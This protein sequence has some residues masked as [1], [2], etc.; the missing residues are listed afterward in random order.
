MPR[1]AIPENNGTFDIQRKQSGSKRLDEL[2]M[3]PGAPESWPHL[4]VPGERS[5]V[6]STG[7]EPSSNVIAM[8]A[9]VNE[10]T[11]WTLALAYA[12][13]ARL[14]P[15]VKMILFRPPYE[16]VTV[17]DSDPSDREARHEVYGAELAARSVSTGA[18]DVEFRLVNEK[19][20]AASN[21]SWSPITGA[22]L[23]YTRTT[24]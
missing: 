1:D 15:H 24:S 3:M 4:G 21:C 2:A 11:S 8:R 23:L 13:R 14:L 17:I 20:I 10:A 6:G 5:D 16:I 12:E 7:L 18:G 19:R 22:D 9:L